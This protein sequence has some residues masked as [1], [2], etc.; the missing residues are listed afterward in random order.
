[1]KAYQSNPQLAAERA[2]LRATDEEVAQAIAQW[3]PR[4]S[5]QRGLFEGPVREQNGLD[6]VDHVCRSQDRVLERRYYRDADGFCR[7]AHSRAAPSGGCSSAR[8]ARRFARDGTERFSRHRVGLH[9]CRARRGRAE[10][11][12]NEP[13]TAQKAIGS[14]SSALRSGR[15]HAHRRGTGRGPLFG[16]RSESDRGGSEFEGQPLVL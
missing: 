10:T 15:D 7:R 6:A 12:Q 13:R 16:G 5:H 2:N 14:R 4:V 1:M 11:Q 3:R 8:R 9:E